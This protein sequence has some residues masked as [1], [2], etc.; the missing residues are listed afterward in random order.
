MRII[1]TI[2][3][4]FVCLG[5]TYAQ[6]TKKAN[7]GGVGRH[8][9]TGIAIGNK[10]YIGLGHT[11][12]T[13]V[14]IDFKDWWQYDPASDSWT[15]KANFPVLIHGAVSFGTDTKGYVGGGST[16]TSMSSFINRWITKSDYDEHGPQIIHKKGL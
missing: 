4:V 10:G 3:V 12:G 1:F 16:L 14:N 11:N 2:Y 5:T 7:L 13:G 8:R 15:Q 6:W 9:G